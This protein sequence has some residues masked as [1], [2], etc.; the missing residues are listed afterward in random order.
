MCPRFLER[1]ISQRESDLIWLERRGKL[2]PE[3]IVLLC[4]GTGGVPSQAKLHPWLLLAW[5]LCYDV[6]TGFRVYGFWQ[7]I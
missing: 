6:M 3:P 1:V 5:F 2:L 4:I 7:A